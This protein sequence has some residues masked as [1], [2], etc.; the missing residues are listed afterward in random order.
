MK[1][2]ITAVTGHFG[3]AAL[4]F[5]MKQ[6]HQSDIVALARD[7]EKASKQ[8]PAG[9]DVRPFDYANPAEMTESLAGIDKLLFIS[10]QPNPDL[11]RLKQHQNVVEA[12]QKAGV[13]FVVYTSFPHADQADNFLSHDH[14]ATEAALK[15]SGLNYAVVRNNWYLE[16]EISVLKPA[17]VGKPF[18]YAAGDGRVG[19][20]LESEYAEG[21]V[22]VLLSKHPKSIY[23]FAGASRTYAELAEAVKVATGKEFPVI[24][25]TLDEYQAGLKAAGLDENTAQI[26]TAIQKLIAEGQ[27]A[28][29]TND[30]PAVISHP[31]TALPDAI[32][33][34]LKS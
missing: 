15:D 5:L 30:L 31:L 11:P 17:V 3:H 7:V 29:E 22:R 8:L 2:A 19:W 14:T 1:Y 34:V 18:V 20:A 6:V 28:E 33:K 24:A 21:A 12:A 9:I 23:E 32:K 4:Q 16:N 26:V 13:D 10:S 27:L 25:T